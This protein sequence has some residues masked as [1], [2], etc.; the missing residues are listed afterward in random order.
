MDRNATF[1][2]ILVI[3]RT[4]VLLVEETRVP[5]ENHRPDKIDRQTLSHSVVSWWAGFELTALL[6][7]HT[8][9]PYDHNYG[10][11]YIIWHS[12]SYQYEWMTHYFQRWGVKK[13]QNPWRPSWPDH[14]LQAKN[15]YSFIIY[16]C[17]AMIL[18][19]FQT[20][21]TMRKLPLTRLHH[22]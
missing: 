14:Y 19:N 12:N 21:H 9:L 16:V 13:C 2:N 10:D 17:I 20:V 4:S 11:P 22:T 3:S 6:V 5:S 8:E 7:I 18:N 1:N 15:N